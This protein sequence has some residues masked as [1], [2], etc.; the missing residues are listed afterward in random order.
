M[1]YQNALPLTDILFQ[2]Q[3]LNYNFS[4][5][6]RGKTRLVITALDQFSVIM[7]FLHSSRTTSKGYLQRN[8]EVIIQSHCSG[9]SAPEPLS[10]PFPEID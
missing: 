1:N 6:T 9:F 8:F 7:F 5:L 3:I 4:E 10:A 2:V